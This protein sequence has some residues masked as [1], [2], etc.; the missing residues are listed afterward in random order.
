ML[1]PTAR[2]A[3]VVLGQAGSAPS[4]R[5]SATYT[6]ST[7]PR[8]SPITGTTKKPTMPNATPVHCVDD[9]IPVSLSRR[10]GTAYLATAPSTRN[11][12]ATREDDPRR[13]L[14]ELAGPDQDRAQ[15]QQPARQ[16]GHDDAEQPDRDGDRHRDLQPAH[17]VTFPQRRRR[18]RAL[19]R[20]R[21]R[22]SGPG[23]AVVGGRS[24]VSAPGRERRAGASP[25]LSVSSWNDTATSRS[26]SPCSRAWWA[27]KC[28]SPPDW[29]STRR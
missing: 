12:A 17:G 2:S 26:A 20:R 9:G 25:S 3:A 23:P 6:P 18:D 7:K 22:T 5:R 21:P 15:D 14:A 8:N 24:V 16:D 11:A 29:S 19:G 4:R 1:S 13:A 10:P 27:Q 28:S